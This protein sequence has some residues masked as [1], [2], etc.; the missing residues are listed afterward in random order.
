MYF[1]LFFSQEFNLDEHIERFQ[2]YDTWAKME[3]EFSVQVR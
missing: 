1:V 2:G 3:Y